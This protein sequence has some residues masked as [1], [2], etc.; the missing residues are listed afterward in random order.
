MLH[1]WKLHCD[2]FWGL[3]GDEGIKTKQPQSLNVK[4]DTWLH[5][6]LQAGQAEP[7]FRHLERITLGLS[8][9]VAQGVTTWPWGVATHWTPCSPHNFSQIFPNNT[10]RHK[11]FTSATCTGVFPGV[12][13]LPTM[14]TGAG[15]VVGVTTLSFWWGL[16]W[17]WG[18][19]MLVCFLSSVSRSLGIKSVLVS[20]CCCI[21]A[22]SVV[23]KLFHQTKI[24]SSRVWTMKTLPTLVFS[25][26]GTKGPKALPVCFMSLFLEKAIPQCFQIP[27][28]KSEGGRKRK[29]TTLGQNSTKQI[30]QVMHRVMSP[31]SLSPSVPQY[32]PYIHLL[33]CRS[34]TM[35]VLS[36]R[37]D[38][39]W[40][41]NAECPLVEMQFTENGPTGKAY[42]EPLTQR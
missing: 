3:T 41:W 37:A 30:K 11:D 26:R 8:S 36:Q 13:C 24:T 10:K 17:L 40:S 32:P 9:P 42:P 16:W 4:R 12:L 29:K 7:S 1:T 27:M 35:H 33:D 6:I 22:S 18:F 28:L 15:W 38:K 23:D 14:L 31:H 19:V 34:C 20:I 5:Q 25:K 21:P 39:T 2:G